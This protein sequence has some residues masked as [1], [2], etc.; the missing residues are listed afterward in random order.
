MKYM[1]PESLRKQYKDVENAKMI[2]ESSDVSSDKNIAV[3]NLGGPV[4]NVMSRES[5][6]RKD[7][8]ERRVDRMTNHIDVFFDHKLSDGV[9]GAMELYEYTSA[10]AIEGQTD[11]AKSRRDLVAWYM[12]ERCL[13]PIE[14][15]YVLAILG[16]LDVLSDEANS[17]RSKVSTYKNGAVSKH[18]MEVMKDGYIPKED[19]GDTLKEYWLVEGQKIDFDLMKEVLTKVNLEAVVIKT[20]QLF[21]DLRRSE[22]F[23]DVEL[24]HKINEAEY[25]YAPICNIIGEDALD[26]V[27]TDMALQI[28]HIKAGNNEILY[29]ARDYYNSVAKFDIQGFLKTLSYDDNS[30][31]ENAI[32]QI[33]GSSKLIDRGDFVLNCGLGA[34]DIY[35]KYRKKTVGR[36][37]NKIFRKQD[38]SEDVPMDLLGATFVADNSQTLEVAVS[39]IVT[40]LEDMAKKGLVVFKSAASKSSPFFVQTN[41]DNPIDLFDNSMING[42]D[43]DYK[44]VENGQFEV[45]KITFCVKKDPDFGI[46]NDL[47]TTFEIQFLTSNNYEESRVG[48]SSHVLYRLGKDLNKDEMRSAVMFMKSLAERKQH[49]L[50]ALHGELSIKPESKD[51]AIF[52]AKQLVD[53]KYS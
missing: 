16:D 26:S 15:D 53:H 51:R 50:S 44:F 36:I 3:N 34:E 41:A 27:M 49:M 21:D 52:L 32:K 9:R 6:E 18:F 1:F 28:R 11:L 33:D 8:I 12:T 13:S 38:Y 10:L 23:S 40:K 42:H 7:F 29:K 30:D 14:S 19:D 35:G 48:T 25:F 4:S 17:Y 47:D 22:D 2:V 31:F 37:A 46:N 45:A 24:L 5:L 39:H 20:L 43:I